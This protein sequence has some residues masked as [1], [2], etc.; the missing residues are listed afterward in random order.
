MERSARDRFAWLENVQVRESGLYGNLHFLDVSDPL[1]VKMLN[2]AEEHPEAFAL[3]HNA[4]GKGEVRDGKYVVT[5]IPEVLSVDIVSDG[6]TNRSLFE[7]K[8]MKRKVKVRDILRDKVLLALDAGRRK[9]LEKILVTS[10]TEAR[11]PLMEA[12]D[13][14]DHRDHMYK[15]MRSCE[16][17][18]NN[19]AAKG[20]HKLLDPEKRIEEDAEDTEKKAEDE[21][22]PEEETEK[23]DEEEGEGGE[24]DERSE[25]EG[26][27]VEGPGEPGEHN[28][29]PDGKKPEEG[30]M[31]SRRKKLKNKPGTVYLTEARVLGLCRLAGVEATADVVTAAT[32]VSL[33][34]AE[35]IIALAKRGQRP[36]NPPRSAAPLRESREQAPI[37]KDLK[38]WAESLKG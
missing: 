30:A 15:A 35:A 2:A 24:S 27:G 28:E 9:R 21:A 23:E 25:M 19:E 5:E 36:S 11:S 16:E 8:E 17:A 12:E 22:G 4:T 26:E 29:G 10:L 34:K 18:G 33:Q 3:S 1:A 7:G 6:G 31:E 20:I 13:G 37:P 32:G 38:S 14:D